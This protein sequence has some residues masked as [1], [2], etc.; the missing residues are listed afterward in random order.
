MTENV[1]RDSTATPSTSSP[2]SRGRDGRK[3]T[4]GERRTDSGIEPATGVRG[5]LVINLRNSR[6][7][8]QATAHTRTL[9]ARIERGRVEYG[10]VSLQTAA[11][12]IE[13]SS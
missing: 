6:V 12:L 10:L 7:T 5:R 9:A 3:A 1:S 11:A 8:L 2:S 4:H 13:V